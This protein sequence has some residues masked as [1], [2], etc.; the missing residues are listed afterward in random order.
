M[1]ILKTITEGGQ[2][3]AH[4]VRMAKQVLKIAS[5]VSLFL[6][7]AFFCYRLTQ[8]P[9]LHYQ[10]SVYYLNAKFLNSNQDKVSV[11]GLFWSKLHRQSVSKRPYN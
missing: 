1:N 4:R 11:N 6:M 7:L 8:I 9:A 3:W 10:A 2:I 5:T